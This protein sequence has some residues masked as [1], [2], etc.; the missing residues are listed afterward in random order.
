MV[1]KPPYDSSGAKAKG[2][3]DLTT[4]PVAGTVVAKGTWFGRHLGIATG[5]G[6]VISASKYH[7]GVVEETFAR[8]RGDGD[9]AIE[10]QPAPGE[11]ADVVARARALVGRPYDPVFFNCEHL[12]SEAYGEGRASPQLRRVARIAA[13]VGLTVAGIVLAR[14]RRIV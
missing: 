13:V 8:F 2:M 6:T 10:R 4:Q 14:G 3:Q 5:A 1:M 7:G 9:V 12:V 11:G